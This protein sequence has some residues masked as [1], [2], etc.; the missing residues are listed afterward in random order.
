MKKPWRA[1]WMGHLLGIHSWAA[2]M[3]GECWCQK[4]FDAM[5][6]DCLMHPQGNERMTLI[7]ETDDC[8]CCA[9]KHFGF[10]E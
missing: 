4:S 3:F 6:F 10:K 7:V 5:C 2:H 1:G 8:I 9:N